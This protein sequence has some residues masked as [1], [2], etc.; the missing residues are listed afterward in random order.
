[1]SINH[2]ILNLVYLFILNVKIHD[3]KILN[4]CGLL[5]RAAGRKPPL[6]KTKHGSMDLTKPHDLW[7]NLLWTVELFGHNAQHHTLCL[8]VDHKEK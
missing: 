2:D 6:S 3:Q 7:N 4:K 5:G 8:W 1:M